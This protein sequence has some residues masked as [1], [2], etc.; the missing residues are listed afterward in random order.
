MKQDSGDE[1][2]LANGVGIPTEVMVPAQLQSSRMRA[3][4]RFCLDRLTQMEAEDPDYAW[5]WH[6]KQRVALGCLKLCEQ[7]ASS[8]LSTTYDLSAEEVDEIM[9]NNPLLENAKASEIDSPINGHSDWFLDIRKRVEAY[10][11]KVDVAE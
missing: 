7:S 10:I 2:G 1:R 9:A 8:D 5:L 6:L 11:R 4:L 3:E